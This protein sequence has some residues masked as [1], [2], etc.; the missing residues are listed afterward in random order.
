M[1]Q[2]TAPRICARRKA[3]SVQGTSEYRHL[4]GDPI[5]AVATGSILL[6]YGIA[7]EAANYTVERHLLVGRKGVYLGIGKALDQFQRLHHRAMAVVV[8]AELQGEQ[9]F[10]RHAA[11][12]SLV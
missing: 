11:I 1:R 10:E 2:D 8:G 6:H 9:E 7:P 3:W 5:D 4:V 12:A